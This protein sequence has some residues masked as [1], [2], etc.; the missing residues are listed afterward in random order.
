MQEHKGT[1]APVTDEG[2]AMTDLAQIKQ[3]DKQPLS[4]DGEVLIAE[5]SIAGLYQ[6]LRLPF[7]V[8]LFAHFTRTTFEC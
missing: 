7:A 2:E 8:S 1:T 3:V 6:L 5:T 4:E